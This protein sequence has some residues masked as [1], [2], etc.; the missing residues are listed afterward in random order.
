MDQLHFPT[1]LFTVGSL[2]WALAKSS[3]AME[4]DADALAPELFNSVIDVYAKVY[5]IAKMVAVAL[6]NYGVEVSL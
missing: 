5:A 2:D 4:L 6:L 3:R 1:T